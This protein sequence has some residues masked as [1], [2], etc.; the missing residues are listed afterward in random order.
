M[1]S[2]EQVRCSQSAARNP[3]ITAHPTIRN[4]SLLE[5]VACNN[6]GSLPILLHRLRKYSHSGTRK[7]A[8]VPVLIHGIPVPISGE[9][10]LFIN[11]H[12]PYFK[13][14]ARIIGE[15][16]ATWLSSAHHDLCCGN[17]Y[18]ERV[19]LLLW[20][21]LQRCTLRHKPNQKSR[22]H[23]LQRVSR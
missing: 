10:L 19:P 23:R 9:L 12:A 14:Y 3:S 7:M 4:W 16:S 15:K 20:C 22:P 17:R 1:R 11:N 8:D 6:F 5:D 13:V 18:F 2:A 21:K